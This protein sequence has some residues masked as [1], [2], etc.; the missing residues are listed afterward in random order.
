MI[1]AQC[2]AFAARDHV[3]AAKRSPHPF[4][5]AQVAGVVKTD[6]LQIGTTIPNFRHG[7]LRQDLVGHIVDE[8]IRDLVNEADLPVFA[9]CDARDHLA[10]GYFRVDHGFATSAP[11]VDH[12][13]KILH[14]GDGVSL[15][16]R[17]FRRAIISENQN[18]V[19]L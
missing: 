6:G 19:K 1:S 13:D 17:G 12:H 3:L 18:L 8:L 5:F 15:E 7:S 14:A 4:V 9:R 11:V 16:Q 10:P 2:F